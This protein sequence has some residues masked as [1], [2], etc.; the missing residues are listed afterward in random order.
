M[1]QITELSILEQLKNI[2]DPDL[3]KDIVTLGFVKDLQIAGGDV[4]F[5]IVLTTPACPVKE[6]FEAEAVRLVGSIAGVENV[7][8]T[9]DAEVPKG[10]G[11]ANNVAVPGVKNIIAVSSGKGGV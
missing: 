11:I 10:R 1:S 9:M 6:A 7:K 5:R 3:R 4:S 2:I 8:V